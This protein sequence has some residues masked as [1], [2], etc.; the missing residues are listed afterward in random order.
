M[1]SPVPWEKSKS[2]FRGPLAS[3]PQAGK[4]TTEDGEDKN[5]VHVKTSGLVFNKQT[6]LAS[7]HGENRVPSGRSSRQCDR[8][9]L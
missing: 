8:R 3:G 2:I 4:A 9:Q 1:A 6:G 7:T 5:T